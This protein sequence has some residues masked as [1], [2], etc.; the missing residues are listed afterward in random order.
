MSKYIV[1]W[2][3]EPG[4]R[5]STVVDAHGT[6]ILRDEA[7]LEAENVTIVDTQ[8][9]VLSILKEADGRK[10]ALTPQL[11]GPTLGWILSA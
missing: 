7:Y 1:V 11:A 8:D 9:A 5:V 3:D 2:K 4:L 10:V 6:P